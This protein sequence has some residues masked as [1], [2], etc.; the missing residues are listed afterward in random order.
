ML[1]FSHQRDPG[2]PAQPI[3]GCLPREEDEVGGD[4]YRSCPV[5]RTLCSHHLGFQMSK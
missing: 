2:G 4:I 5:R 3:T 1:S